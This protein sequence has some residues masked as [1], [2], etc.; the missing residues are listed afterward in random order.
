[1]TNL[2][3]GRQWLDRVRQD[4]ADGRRYTFAVLEDHVDGPQ[5]VA[6]VVLKGSRRSGRHPRWVTGRRPGRADGAS[7]RARSPR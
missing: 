4:W 5:L 3:E 6:N 7:P 2:A 1:M